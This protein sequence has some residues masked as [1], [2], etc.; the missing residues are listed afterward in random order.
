MRPKQQQQKL[1]STS[2]HPGGGPSSLD[3]P[4]PSSS[5][6]VSP[7]P[8]TTAP[9]SQASKIPWS[10]IAA[11]ANPGIGGVSPVAG[12]SLTS[13]G[14]TPGF[15]GTSGG[16][17]LLS[18]YPQHTNS[19]PQ[20]SFANAAQMSLLRTS[21]S[22]SIK[23]AN[24][25]TKQQFGA[26]PGGG[27]HHDK[28]Y[29]GDSSLNADVAY[30]LND[31]HHH[32]TGDTNNIDNPNNGGFE[33][34]NNSYNSITGEKNGSTGSNDGGITELDSQTQA[35]VL[36]VL[37]S[38]SN[39]KNFN[40]DE[41][42]DIFMSLKRKNLIKGAAQDNVNRTELFFSTA[43]N[44]PAMLAFDHHHHSHG[45]GHNHHHQGPGHGQNHGGSGQPNSNSTTS[46]MDL[47]RTNSSLFSSL[48][49]NDSGEAISSITNSIANS[50]VNSV[51]NSPLISG[52]QLHHSTSATQSHSAIH[53]GFGNSTLAS[54]KSSIL[55]G[56][57]DFSGDQ[58]FLL[59]PN[60]SL[61][62]RSSLLMDSNVNARGSP[63]SQNSLV[64]DSTG[65]SSWSPFIGSTASLSSLASSSGIGAGSLP[66]GIITS[67][68]AN[69]NAPPPGINI[70]AH[71]PPEQLQWIYKDM[72]GNV[73]G[74]FNGLVMQEW[75]AKNWF[76][77]DLLICRVDESE[78][79]MLKDFILRVGNSVTP[80]LIPLPPVL[81]QQQQQQLQQDA[82]ARQMLLKKQQQQQFT[83]QPTQPT[84]GWASPIPAPMSPMS[85]WGQLQQ[86]RLQ[87]QAPVDASSSFGT[88]GSF[89]GSSLAGPG[90]SGSQVNL[91]HFAND[92]WQSRAN[93][94]IPHTPRRIPS[95]SNLNNNS[96]LENSLYGGSVFGGIGSSALNANVGAS[97][98]SGTLTGGGVNAM[99]LSGLLNN[100]A[101]G[102]TGSSGLSQLDTN[103]G[104]VVTG[105]KTFGSNET[106]VPLG[107]QDSL[108]VKASTSPV[109]NLPSGLIGNNDNDDII[110]GHEAVTAPI[111]PIG[112]SM[113]SPT[114]GSSANLVKEVQAVAS[115]ATKENVE[116]NDLA[117][118]LAAVEV[119]TKKDSQESKRSDVTSSTSV[120]APV[121]KE[122]VFKKR[123]SAIAAAVAAMA[124]REP[125]HKPPKKKEVKEQK[126]VKDR[127]TIQRE[128][129]EKEAI[130]RELMESIGAEHSYT[131]S[132]DEEN[133]HSLEPFPSAT[134]STGVSANDVTPSDSST[135][136][137]KPASI[138]PVMAPWAK[139]DVVKPAKKTLSLKEI[140]EIEAAER[141][142]RKVQASVSKPS[143]SSSLASVATGNSVLVSGSLMSG[144]I[145]SSSS[146]TSSANAAL[147][148]TSTWATVGRTSAPKKTLAQIQKEEE[149]AS[150]KKQG[151][152][153]PVAASVIAASLGASSGSPAGVVSGTTKRFSEVA[154]SSAGGKVGSAWTTVGPGGRKSSIT[155]GTASVATPVSKV[156]SARPSTTTVA[157]SSATTGP[158]SSKAIAAN[159][160][161]NQ[162]CKSSLLDL[163][164][165]VS[166][167][168]LLSMLLSLPATT[169]SKEI[170]ADIIY[171]NSTTM[172]GRRFSE[173][174]V[175]R[176]L[177]VVAI[178]NGT[179]DKSNGSGNWSDVLGKKKEADAW[180]VQFKVVGKKKARKE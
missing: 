102:S 18:N 90:L 159:D 126:E 157:V 38:N 164:A 50:A 35:E 37:R 163:T 70:P 120:P 147:P 69:T 136:S 22:N 9:R 89:T 106:S 148:T 39:G 151:Y 2:G 127:E 71:I 173:E 124:A 137:P 172:D 24:G 56:S 14:N 97:G 25:K 19:H 21:S 115:G 112:S 117:E 125:V 174:F 48:T 119:A 96:G 44:E 72:H 88:F 103:G 79:C 54:S 82:F 143:T 86:N 158:Q 152:A 32:K 114:G 65:N 83:Q 5:S 64:A 122:K 53:S 165:G 177:K 170:I 33:A 66:P 47:H 91:T 171:S 160:E 81:L 42:L 135:T 87:Q 142:S 154:T 145:G 16:S 62:S 26:V 31:T 110:I 15:A 166:R 29:V 144:L 85:P 17:S 73:Q 133:E 13:L 12:S 134:S 149:E 132:Y 99:A 109:G 113:P 67:P 77:N 131:P 161:F 162:W 30:V 111:N 141:K 80:F 60:Q 6:I 4:K 20:M 36:E 178:E 116:A 92:P 59:N 169:E 49:S 11:G 84:P 118:K 41:M 1:S 23:S 63:G 107:S 75:Y 76:K 74:P 95:V 168:E 108:F 153:T 98:P 40:I 167:S 34:N 179:D 61:T 8:P 105:A 101:K 94:S 130:E 138:K 55:A 150:K 123:E 100:A 10:N 175:N 146:T 155:P 52:G 121:H 176:R 7:I 3:S 93:G 180:N 129:K 27:E 104:D 139:K 51:T 58:S 46:F 78:Y 45:H 28:Q 140:Q 128:Q 57:S 68:L 156:A 43:A